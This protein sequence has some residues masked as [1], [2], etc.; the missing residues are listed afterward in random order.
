MTAEP[1]GGFWVQS[2]SSGVIT[3]AVLAKENRQNKAGSMGPAPWG[4]H[5]AQRILTMLY[6]FLYGFYGLSLIFVADKTDFFL[7]YLP[8]IT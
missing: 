6:S 7:Q 3:E 8:T 4:K 1:H 5:R 2:E